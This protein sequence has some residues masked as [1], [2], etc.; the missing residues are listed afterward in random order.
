MSFKT[1]KYD[2]RDKN[3]ML[4]LYCIIWRGVSKIDVFGEFGQKKK[5]ASA[6]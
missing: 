3:S 1:K 5:S 2:T 4:V 6:R